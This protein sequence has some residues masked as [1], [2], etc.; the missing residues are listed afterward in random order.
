MDRSVSH[1]RTTALGACSGFT[2]FE[3]LLSISI[4]AIVAALIMGAFRV[5]Y[6]AWEKGDAVIADVQRFRGVMDRIKRQ[7]AAAA[8]VYTLEDQEV[9]EIPVIRFAGTS[10]VIRFVSDYSLVPGVRRGRVAVTYQ[11]EEIPEKGMRLVF[12][13]KPLILVDPEAPAEPDPDAFYELLTGPAQITFE[14]L[15][16]DRPEAEAAWTEEWRPELEFSIPAAVRIWVQESDSDPPI[17]IISRLT[18]AE[19]E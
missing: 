1:V 18:A 8:P 4:L 17:G 12:Y 14:Y 15:R 19:P 10:N 11:V 13:E 7:L 2:L 5:S 16:P 6:R 3:L 9:E